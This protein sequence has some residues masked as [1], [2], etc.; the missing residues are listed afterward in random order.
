MGQSRS[1]SV[2][3]ARLSLVLAAVLWSLGSL[4]TRLLTEPTSLG[5]NRP[6]L[7]P[8]HIAFFRGLIAGLVFV[9][10]L[11][12]NPRQVR[13]RPV[14][15]GMVA[16]FGVMS[17]LYM[18]AL[19]LGPAANAILLQNTA[20]FWVYVIGVYLLGNPADRRSWRAILLGVAGALIIV[21]GNWPRGA[22]ASGGQ[23][24]VLLMGLGSGITYAGVVL[25]LHFLRNESS[26]W[27][28]VLNLCG[29]AAV[30]GGFV[31]ARQ[32]WNGTLDWLR[33]PT[34]GQLVLLAV[35]G[36]LQMAVPYWLFARGLRSVS[37]QE[38]GII[39][40]LEPVLNPIWAYLVAPDKEAPTVW[41][42]I[43]GLVLLGALAWRYVPVRP[44]SRPDPLPT[45]T[46]FEKL[47]VTTQTVRLDAGPTPTPPGSNPAS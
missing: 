26:Q 46:G 40:L 38:A 45:A 6:A 37:A 44:T 27:L 34:T 18:S 31:L 2:T 4:F 30:I 29:S 12:A 15:V 28:T 17:G 32:G 9:P 24:A 42:L 13:F 20:P 41:T 3:V 47:P 5:L 35:F 21:A 23:A 16:C 1:S 25:F 14:M 43:G 33:V 11:V 7:D 39:T 10:A 36:I 19:A 8:L 22:D